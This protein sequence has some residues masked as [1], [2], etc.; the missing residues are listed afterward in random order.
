MKNIKMRMFADVAFWVMVIGGLVFSMG[1]G[2]CIHLVRGEVSNWSYRQ[3]EL[4]T[5]YIQSYVDGQLRRVEDVA[6]TFADDNI[7]HCLR[8]DSDGPVPITVTDKF[9]NLKEESIFYMLDEFLDANP[10]ICGIALGLEPGVGS[11]DRG[12]YGFAC[13]AT[14]VS[15]NINHLR[16]GEVN[17]YRS[18]EWYRNA[19][20]SL[21]SYW[22]LPFRETSMEK[23]VTCF[24]IPILSKD[25][26][27]AY[28]VLAL[29]IDTEAFREKCVEIAP[30]PGAEIC[31]IDREGRFISHKDESLLLTDASTTEKYAAVCKEVFS[32][33]GQELRQ[34]DQDGTIFHITQIQRNGWKVCS[35]FSEEDVFGSVE[36]M[37]HRIRLIAILS[38][39]F[40]ALTFLWLFR[41]LQKASMAKASIDSE[42]NVASKIQ[43]GLL[44][45]EDKEVEDNKVTDIQAFIRPAKMVGGDLYDYCIKDGRLFFCIGDVSGKGVP[46]SL[47]MSEVL[48]LFRNETQHSATAASIVSSINS[49]L[50]IGNRQSMF[51][52]FFAGILELETGRLDYC[53][54]GHNAPVLA[55]RFLSAQ[56][57][58]PLAV[59][60]GI[61]FAGHEVNMAPG[62]FLVLYTDGISEAEDVDKK[63]FGDDRLLAAIEEATAMAGQ[64]AAGVVDHLLKHVKEHTGAAEQNDDMTVLVVRYDKER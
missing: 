4:T 41:G 40:M 14:N 29:D 47:F 1:F 35:E 44:K 57:Q 16:L 39:I 7:G 42:L 46:A 11:F 58:L 13:Y 64:T 34:I 28:G 26:T 43:M 30:F 12:P 54:A 38:I 32:E 6:Y 27:E 20:E 21:N 19:C 59:F 36:L 31:L 49:T 53:S 61:P 15:G 8:D 63:L 5:W 55:G 48:A 56:P 23:V 50:A 18:K 51:C 3:A 10:Q 17:D 45:K 37:K 60:D 24:S 25:G 52:T 2:L 62:D 9:W 33:N 22:S